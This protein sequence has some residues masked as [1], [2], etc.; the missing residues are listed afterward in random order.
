MAKPGKRAWC[1]LRGQEVAMLT[2][3]LLCLL[4][5]WRLWRTAQSGT[6]PG[7]AGSAQIL[8]GWKSKDDGDEEDEDEE[9][10]D[11]E[12]EDEQDEPKA[13]VT[14]SGQWPLANLTPAADKEDDPESFQNAE[15]NLFT[16]W[17]YPHGAPEYVRLNI[18]SWRRHSHGRCA[19]P[20]FLNEKNIHQYIPDLPEEYFKIPYQAAR[21]DV[22]RYAVIYHN[23]GIYMD[24]DFLVQEDLDPVIDVL[25]MDLVSYSGNNPRGKE[26]PPDFSSNFLGGRKGSTFHK[27]VYEAQ[28][29]K[30]QKY[31]P[32]SQKGKPVNGKEVF[33]CFAEP[34]VKCDVP[35]ASIGEGVSHGEL[36]R[37]RQDG[38][39]FTSYCFAGDQSFV[40]A[41]MEGVLLHAPLLA[42]ATNR[43]DRNGVKNPF[44]RIAYHL[45]NSMTSL[46]TWSCK[47]LSSNDT[48]IGSLYMRSFTNGAGAQL[49]TGKYA[50]AFRTKYPEF[51]EQNR[52]DAIVPCVIKNPFAKLAL[53]PTPSGRSNGKCNI[54]SIAPPVPDDIPNALELNVQ[55]WQKHTKDVCN[56]PILVND[57]NVKKLI[58][59]LPQEY[60]RLPGPQEKLDFIRHG[61][62]Y[63][64]GGM[65]LQWDVVFLR[66]MS[67]VIK[68][69]SKHDLVS[70][71]ERKQG[72]RTSCGDD[73][74]VLFTAGKQG[75]RFHGAV[76]QAAKDAVSSHCPLSDKDKEKLCCFDGQHQCHIPGGSLGSLS[77]QIKKEYEG[78][79]QEMT[80]YCY[81]EAES[82]RPA[83]FQQI[84]D[85]TPSMKKGDARFK[86]EHRRSLLEALALFIPISMAEDL[87][88]RDLFNN[89]KVIGA[90]YSAS[91]AVD[92]SEDVLPCKRRVMIRKLVDSL[93]PPQGP[94]ECH[95][96]SLQLDREPVAAK[97]NLASWRRHMPTSCSDVI[98]NDANVQEWLPDVP[99]EYFKL[100]GPE[101][102]LD[103][104]RHGLLYHHGGL[105][106]KREVILTES[107]ETFMEIAASVDIFS[108]AEEGSGT[109]CGGSFQANQILGGRQASHYHGV[110]WHVVKEALT[111]HC[112]LADRNKEIICCFD[113][114]VSCHI[115]G[116]SLGEGMSIKVKRWFEAADFP[117]ESHCLWGQHSVRPAYF[118]YVLDHKPKLHDA[119][120]YFTHKRQMEL[121]NR[122]AFF[123]P[124]EQRSCEEF[125]ETETVVGAVYM[126]SF[127]R[128]SSSGSLG[129]PI[130]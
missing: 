108:S 8:R 80:S 72:E 58:P 36:R 123:V 20:I 114:D 32:A 106:M 54:F 43:F 45:F 61:L 128:T 121:L 77:I 93:I 76:W 81:S 66:D 11:L 33:C 35:W 87:S 98:I 79:D 88:C 40:P 59:D 96:F 51:N 29:K 30:M 14:Q 21:S 130:G 116:G 118:Q 102:K 10:D 34:D 67:R 82:F 18:E 63:H 83:F 24:T 99:Q 89:E 7:S 25:N 69:I 85:H 64:Q 2:L 1:L 110:A 38:E 92:S 39:E 6:L 90:V 126:K 86:S 84:L 44:G 124:F 105:V 73:W 75:S 42:D 5:L 97:L 52:L 112:P 68:Q 26:C 125:L 46:Q 23:G 60:F 19:E 48:F 37:M 120:Q 104:I 129:C 107:L 117:V 16:L 115:P 94:R 47:R 62:I 78:D 22:V 49:V 53:L 100:P 91:F 101:E 70:S 31:C 57:S 50:D 71:A 122:T 17:E 27:T 119:M 3:W 113:A 55:S 28:I 9:D 15:C 12:S 56:E 103:F 74:Q 95:V 4:S 111:K 13:K 41:D 65:V 127:G 109:R